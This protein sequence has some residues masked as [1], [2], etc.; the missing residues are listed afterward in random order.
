VTDEEAERIMKEEEEKKRRREAGESEEDVKM[1][2]ENSKPDNED[3]KE[4]GKDE[5]KL[6]KD[7]KPKQKPNTGNGG[8]TDKYWWIQTLDDV[9][10]FIKV[11]DRIA[12][13]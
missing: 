10:V 5:V 7:G 12:S 3:S 4:E 1:S 9:T 13:K 11:P 2:E 6:G 8:M